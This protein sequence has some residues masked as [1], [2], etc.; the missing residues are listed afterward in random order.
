MHIGHPRIDVEDSIA[1]GIFKDAG[2]DLLDRCYSKIIDVA[3]TFPVS[4]P[5]VVW[6]SV[7]YAVRLR[8]EYLRLSVPVTS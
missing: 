2:Y 4:Q 7:L 5:G 1:V 8:T 3:N 6:C